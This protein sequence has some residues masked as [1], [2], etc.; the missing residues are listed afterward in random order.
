MKK[1]TFKFVLPAL[2]LLITLC[3]A[4]PVDKQDLAPENQQKI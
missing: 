1:M 4:L 3:S 2:V